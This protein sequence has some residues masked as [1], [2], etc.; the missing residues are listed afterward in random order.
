MLLPTKTNK[1]LMHWKGPFE[2][3]E[4]VGDLDYRIKVKGKV[5]LFHINMLKLYVERKVGVVIGVNEEGKGDKEIADPELRSTYE[6]VVNLRDRLESTCEL[7]KQNIERASRKQAK[8]Y[9][10]SPGLGN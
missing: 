5:K 8:I 6:Y 7:V 9:N 4:R 1:L 2:V 10:R 3:V